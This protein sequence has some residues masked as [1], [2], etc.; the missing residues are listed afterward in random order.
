M[1]DNQECLGINILSIQ[2]KI[3]GAKHYFDK[4]PQYTYENI[5][6]NKWY[7][8]KQFTLLVDLYEEK[9]GPLIIKNIGTGIIPEM[10]EAG[11]LPKMS[12]QE[13]L[14]SLSGSYHSANRGTNIGD[15]K[16]IK[17]GANH[18]IMENSTSHNCKLEEGV[19]LGGIEALGGKNPR[20]LQRTCVKKGDPFCTFD[21]YW[22]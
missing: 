7:P 15:W 21:I 9:M 11:V 6:P 17:E 14:K 2:N 20:V 4:I 13:F 16:V 10:V 5:E 12:P 22:Q 18:I 8:M 19:V 1:A 3:Y